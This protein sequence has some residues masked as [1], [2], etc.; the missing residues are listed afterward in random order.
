MKKLTE[1]LRGELEGEIRVDEPLAKHTT[2]KVGGPAALMV[3]PQSEA[4][5]AALV[6]LTAET[7][8]PLLILGNGSNLLFGDQGFNGVVV[9]LSRLKDFVFEGETVTA[10]A[11]ALLPALIRQAAQNSLGGLEGLWGIPAS[12]GGALKMNASAY[13]LEISEPLLEV[14]MM[15]RN[16]AIKIFPRKKLHFSYRSA[17]IDNNKV[18]LGG[19]FLLR[20]RAQN[21]ILN[22]LDRVRGKRQETQPLDQPSAGSIFKNPEGQY[23]GQL[24]ESAGLKGFCLGGASISNKH[25]N[26]IV[27]CG[28]ARAA[29]VVNLIDL[30]KE[31]VQERCGVVLHEEV[32]RVGC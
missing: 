5:L 1:L 20:N 15:D 26:F 32:I 28:T 11:G 19:K 21:D 8:A 27:T 17:D 13:G 14:R 3:W 31:R 16:G 6:A 29:D 7:Q 30:I 9:K 10:G 25:A 18:I 4:D 24:I 23:A 12:V 22:D 2:L